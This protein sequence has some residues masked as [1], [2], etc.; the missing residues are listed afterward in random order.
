MDPKIKCAA[1]AITLL[2]VA[3]TLEPHY[4]RP[5]A[6]MPAPSEGQPSGPLATDTGWREFF[7]DT[8]LQQLIA[9]ALAN[10]RDLR[11]AALNVES[12]Q[13]RYRIQRAEL[14]PTI[15]ASATEEVEEFPNG[16]LGTPS[17]PG[18][19]GAATSTGGTTIRFYDVGIGFTSYELDFFG[20]IRSL[21]HSA[22]E[23]YFSYGETRRSAELTLVAEVANAYLSVLADQTLLDI[24]RDTLKSQSDSYEL[25]R[26]MFG[27]GTTTELALRQAETTVDSARA[28]LAQYQRALA[29]DRDALQLL[30]GARI[31]DGIDFSHGLDRGTVVMELQEGIPSDVLVRRPDVLAAEH[32]LRSANAQIGAARAAF[33]PA[34]T[35]TGSFGTA[36]TELSGLFKEGSRAWTFSPLISV[37]LFAGGANVANLQATKLARA[38]AVAQYEKAIQ[39]AF[40]EVADGLAA[41][42][43]LDDQLT[44][45]QALVSASAVAYRLADMRFRGGVDSYLS[46]LDA[47]RSLYS[48]QQ[49]LQSVRLLRLQNLVTLYKALGGGLVEH[50]SA[51]QAGASP[52]S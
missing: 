17:G 40:R 42:Q 37:P 13:A 6:P 52:A 45:Q 11:V 28:D 38:T 29:Q 12:A 24:T 15:D 9:L 20:R 43:T 8:Q 1:G 4:H 47:Q 31:P 16:V 2:L 23:Q 39:T 48:A 22:L 50:G 25:T 44:A 49:Q 3:C 27:A 35:L 10:N 19:G 7:P 18:G 21:N 34:I 41:R 26:R 46:A 5:D 36:S 14:F 51:A 30:L 32:Q 33:L